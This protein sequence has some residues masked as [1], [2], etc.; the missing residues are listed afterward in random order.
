MAAVGA[1]EGVAAVVAVAAVAAV[2]G[3]AALNLSPVPELCCSFL[4]VPLT[5]CSPERCQAEKRC[6][7]ARW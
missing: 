7:T 5:C 2:V 1:E 6:Q 3:A 4:P